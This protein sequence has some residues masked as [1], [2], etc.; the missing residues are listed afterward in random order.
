MFT[1]SYPRCSIHKE[2]EESMRDK[3]QK[4]CMATTARK[5]VKKRGKEMGREAG[6]EKEEWTEIKEKKLTGG[7]GYRMV[8]DT[9]KKLV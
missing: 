4:E 8:R 9:G 5:Q 6:E 1:V 2:Y 3:V 7:E